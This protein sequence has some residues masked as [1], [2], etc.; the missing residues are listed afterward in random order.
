MREGRG[1]VAML[2]GA[3]VSPPLSGPAFPWGEAIFF[4]PAR[5]PQEPRL[6]DQQTLTL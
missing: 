4:P 2:G 5:V 1:R 3:L 6:I